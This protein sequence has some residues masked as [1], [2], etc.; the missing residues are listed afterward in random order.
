MTEQ[1]IIDD[2]IIRGYPLREIDV[3]EFSDF[4]ENK[5]IEEFSD[6]FNC[7]Y[8]LLNGSISYLIIE[9][10]NL[11]NKDIEIISELINLEVLL[12]GGN[13]LSDLHESFYKLQK[14]RRLSLARNKFNKIPDVLFKLK[15]LEK[16]YLYKN[17]IINI[18]NKSVDNVDN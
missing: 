4:E 3:E 6:D 14:L 2:L 10:K 5:D 13:N 7:S 9:S 11:C 18:F 17:K 15:N 16:L 8:S 1:E 12:L